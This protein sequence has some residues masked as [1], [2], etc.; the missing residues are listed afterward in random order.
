MKTFFLKSRENKFKMKKTTLTLLITFAFLA[1]FC[2]QQAKAANGE[3]Q[4]TGRLNIFSFHWQSNEYI[5]LVSLSSID[6]ICWVLYPDEERNI[7]YFSDREQHEDNRFFELS[8]EY[9]RQFFE[10]TNI[11]ETDSV[12][13]FDYMNDILSVFSVNEL[14]VVAFLQQVPLCSDK[15]TL[16]DYHIGFAINNDDLLQ[17]PEYD[18]SIGRSVLIYVGK[19]HPFVRGGLTPIVWEQINDENFP[20]DRAQLDFEADE[21]HST[22]LFVWN[23]YRLYLQER[24]ND[25]RH[26]LESESRHL[27]VFDKNNDKLVLE[28]M[29]Y[30]GYFGFEALLVK[31]YE[32]YVHNIP[33]PAIGYLFQDRP[34]VMLHFDF[35]WCEYFIFL[36]P[37]TNNFWVLCDDRFVPG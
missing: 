32:E 19:T 10:R 28:K 36:D 23:Q 13:L 8:A 25:T 2:N 6:P 18:F 24:S 12:F 30:G 16:C 21:T 4:G 14:P 5:S 35:I 22:Y 9:R 31:G 1:L 34:P 11:S 15:P 27:L 7:V 37:T 20:A 3:Y 33:K 17:F 26:W 29:F